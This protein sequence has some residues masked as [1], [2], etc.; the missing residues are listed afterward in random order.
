MAKLKY[1]I[2]KGVKSKEPCTVYVTLANETKLN[3]TVVDHEHFPE[4]KKVLEMHGFDHI[5]VMTFR[6][7]D[8]SVVKLRAL[9]AELKN[10]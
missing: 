8:S 1:C 7:K 10:L 9:N 6:S 2:V 4:I 3:P 5:M